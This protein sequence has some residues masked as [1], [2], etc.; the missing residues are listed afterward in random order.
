MVFLVDNVY[1]EK[2]V[3]IVIMYLIGYLQFCSHFNT[4]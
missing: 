1:L 4:L 3:I 2:Y